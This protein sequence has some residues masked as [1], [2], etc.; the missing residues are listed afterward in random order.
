MKSLTSALGVEHACKSAIKEL[1]P[2][3]KMIKVIMSLVFK[4]ICV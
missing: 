4:K 1:L 3:R 2:Y